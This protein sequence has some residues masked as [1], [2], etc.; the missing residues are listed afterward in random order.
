MFVGNGG[1]ST[2]D[3]NY[4]DLT[5]SRKEGRKEGNVFFNDALITFYL[6]LYGVIHMVKDHSDIGNPLSSLHAKL[7]S[8]GRSQT[9]P[10]EAPKFEPDVITTWATLSD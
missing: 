1:F 3:H 5:F 2:V 4:S 9:Q 6:W 8:F 7:L 10:F